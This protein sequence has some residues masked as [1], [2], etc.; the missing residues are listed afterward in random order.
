MS[1]EPVAFL[2]VLHMALGQTQGVLSF[3]LEN[4]FGVRGRDYDDTYEVTIT[5]LHAGEVRMS[6]AVSTRAR[7]KRGPRV[8]A[9][10]RTDD[11]F[12]G[13]YRKHE[14]QI[15]REPNGS[16]YIIVR[17]PSGSCC[18]DG[19]RKGSLDMSAAITQA[20]VGSCLIPS[21]LA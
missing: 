7:G 18:Y 17:S 8:K 19:W 9:L 15:D 10:I 4:P 1:A 13:T 5:P 21:P 6:Q 11:H 3:D 12:Y 2:H 14:I 16:F 20:L